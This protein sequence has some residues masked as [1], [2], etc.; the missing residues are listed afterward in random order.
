[1]STKNL[2]VLVSGFLV[3]MLIILSGVLLEDKQHSDQMK[4]CVAAGK[5]WVR[6]YSNY[7]E[8]KEVK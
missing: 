2:V 4:A 5:D 8:C 7:Y 3:F 1:M 6:D